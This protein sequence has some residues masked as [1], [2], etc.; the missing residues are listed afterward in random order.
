MNYNIIGFERRFIPISFGINKQF[1]TLGS[2]LKVDLLNFISQVHNN[3]IQF[4]FVGWW[5]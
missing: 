2:F 5:L 1:W 3:K 4:F